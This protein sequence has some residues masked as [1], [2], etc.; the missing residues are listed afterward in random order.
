MKRLILLMIC[1]LAVP[2]MAQN[3]WSTYTGMDGVVVPVP[4]GWNAAPIENGV[5]VLSQDELAATWV[6]WFNAAPGTTDDT[7]LNQ[8]VDT[9][10]AG[11]GTVGNVSFDSEVTNIATLEY[12]NQ[13]GLAAVT[14][15]VYGSRILGIT[16]A[17]D[18]SAY[19]TYWPLLLATVENMQ[20]TDAQQSSPQ[21]NNVPQSNPVS[22]DAISVDLPPGWIIS[23][24]GPDF[25][26]VTDQNGD[27]ALVYL[28]VSPQTP[29]LSLTSCLN[30]FLVLLGELGLS[31]IQITA[32]EELDAQT[33][34]AE[35]THSGNT[36]T[37][38]ASCN[39]SNNQSYI[40]FLSVPN[41][42]FNTYWQTQIT[43]LSLAQFA[44]TEQAVVQQQPSQ[45]VTNPDDPFAVIGGVAPVGNVQDLPSTSSE[46]SWQQPN[47]ATL[48]YT[49]WVD[50][51]EG[52]FSVEVPQG[53]TVDGG[54]YDVFGTKLPYYSMLSPDEE[55]LAFVGQTEILLSLQP[56]PAWRDYAEGDTVYAEGNYYV[57]VAA[58][59]R[60][61]EA[62][63]EIVQTTIAPLCE[64]FS[65]TERRDLPTSSGL[66][67]DQSA[68]ISS[69][70][71]TYNC[72]IEGVPAV[73]YQY[74]ATYATI[75]PNYGEV[76]TIQDVLG[77]I[78]AENRAEEAVTAMTHAIQTFLLNQDWVTVQQ[79]Q[80]PQQGNMSDSE[81]YALLSEISA[82]Q[83]ETT[84]SIIGNIGGDV[85]W[86]WEWDYDYGW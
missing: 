68:F 7:C 49:T 43:I 74:A 64:Q 17:T 69:G 52:A 78:A 28:Q 42:V 9:F 66:T 40:R 46:T 37:A 10:V 20:F 18:V 45:A 38:A 41:A 61:V 59:K 62:A 32:S 54:T 63:E 6:Q 82:M 8:V 58:Y 26:L 70:E 77:F 13:N 11:L 27:G 14:C 4:P 47:L 48:T 67:P 81:Y 29:D 23:D 15:N 56:S 75:D 71:V 5:I 39:L 60:G 36:A 34:Y 16:L 24:S 2:V 19:D 12:D 83:H 22:N 30:E 76:W 80:L 1:L 85:T 84:M 50:P 73:G 25:V 21:Q 33:I 57:R 31:D 65:I 35:F 72:V 53:W 86:E 3:D 44:G 55:I 51:I 79:Q